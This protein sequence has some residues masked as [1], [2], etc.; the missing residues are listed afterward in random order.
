M[1]QE[2]VD[3]VVQEVYNHLSNAWLYNK[4]AKLHNKNSFCFY[5]DKA[6]IIIKCI[7]LI[8]KN[9]IKNIKYIINDDKFNNLVFIVRFK[10][11]NNDFEK[12]S[13]SFHLPLIY[14]NVIYNRIRESKKCCL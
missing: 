13:F 12:N 10:F 1:E 7:E 6:N 3:L 2:T 11:L 14:K 5:S 4:K 9:H 8:N